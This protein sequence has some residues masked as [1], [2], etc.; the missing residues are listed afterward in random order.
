M[1]DGVGPTHLDIA[2]TPDG[3]V[4]AG[5]IDAYTAPELADR[6][7]PLPGAGTDVA[8]DLAA[9]EF[10]DSSGLG[11]IIDAHRRAMEAGRRIVLAKP[12]AAVVRLIEIS[13]LNGYL[14][15]SRD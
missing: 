7:T 15:L 9:V 6:L 14:T 12:S 10:I 11:V 1:H 8:I 2:P 3:V 4:L 13:G 5:E